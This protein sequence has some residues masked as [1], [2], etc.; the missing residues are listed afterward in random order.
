MLL[1][2]RISLIL[3]VQMDAVDGECVSLV[4]A[5]AK[6]GEMEKIE[7]TLTNMKPA[8]LA[9]SFIGARECSAHWSLLRIA[10]R[11]LS[12]VWGPYTQRRN[13]NC[14]VCRGI[15]AVHL[16]GDWIPEDT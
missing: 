3:L 15:C 8:D 11:H 14:S 13:T 2:I 6:S 5:M 16:A 4:F 12:I 1:S 9:G 10:R 7:V